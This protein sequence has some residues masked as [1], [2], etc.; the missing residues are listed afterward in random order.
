MTKVCMLVSKF[1]LWV[2]L[3][4]S[5]GHY[6]ISVA[7]LRLFVGIRKSCTNIALPGVKV[8]SQAIVR[9]CLR[10]GVGL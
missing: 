7:G 4:T 1:F 5:L 8:Q 10:R 2:I 6:W 9:K 3:W